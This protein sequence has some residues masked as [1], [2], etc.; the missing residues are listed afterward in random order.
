MGLG[1]MAVHNLITPT[2]QRV[3]FIKETIMWTKEELTE[4]RNRAELEAGI[5]GQTLLWQ[6][7]CINL[8]ASASHLLEVTDRICAGEITA[9]DTSTAQ[10]TLGPDKE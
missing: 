6:I 2:R 3:K 4:I 1:E 8:A 7:A 9:V 10:G 5:K